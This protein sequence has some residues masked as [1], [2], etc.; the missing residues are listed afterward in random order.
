MPEFVI[1]V[2]NIISPLCHSLLRLEPYTVCP[3]RCLYCYSKWY[4]TSSAE[5]VYPRRFILDR[6]NIIVRKMYRRGLRYIPFRLSTLVDPF[7]QHEELYRFTEK[8]LRISSKYEYPL[9]IN[10]KSS[11]VAREPWVNLIKKLAEG[12]GILIQISISTLKDEIGRRLEPSAPPPSQRLAIAKK[13]SELGIPVSIRLSPFIPFISPTLHEEIREAVDTFRECS[14]RHIIFE[15]LRIEP[16]NY[17]QLVEIASGT[18][19]DFESYN[20]RKVG[21]LRPLIRVSRGILEPIYRAYA[22][23]ASNSSIALATCKEGLYNLHTSEDCCGFYI[24][25]SYARRPTLWDVYRFVLEYGALEPERIIHSICKEGRFICS[26]NLDGYPKEISKPLKYHERR[27]L[28]VLYNKDIL[29]HLT[30]VLSI[31]NGKVLVKI[32]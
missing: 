31:E 29:E 19:T 2:S 26:S 21:G 15:G 10:T 7:P 23:L 18:S 16:E 22:R 9:I 11:L 1:N 20:I 30:P 25:K 3:Y 27:L 14:I 4:L 32:R 17:S 5:I 28:K 13:L 12:N 8:L 24:F 6:F